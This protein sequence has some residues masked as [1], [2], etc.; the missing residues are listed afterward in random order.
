MFGASEEIHVEHLQNNA[1]NIVWAAC[2]VVAQ[3]IE[4]LLRPWYS[5]RYFPIP[6]TFFSVAMMMSLPLILAAFNLLGGI[7]PFLHVQQSLGM[8]DIGTLAQVYFLVSAIHAFRLWRRMIRPETE[9]HSEF[10]GPALPFFRLLPKGNSWWFVRI[11]LE[12]ATV[13][14]TAIVLQDLHIFQASLG[15]YLRFA[16]LALFVKNWIG[17]YRGWQYVRNLLDQRNAGPLIGKLVD[18]TA[19][20]EELAPIHLA[21]FPKNLSPEIRAA[22][23]TQLANTYSVENPLHGGR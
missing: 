2:S 17:W 23:V 12:P 14:I 6:V 9:L 3:P 21:S 5:S 8:F 7:I 22:A 10:E 1:M 13:L 11:V 18:N 4:I 16:A 20:E 19:T 15:F